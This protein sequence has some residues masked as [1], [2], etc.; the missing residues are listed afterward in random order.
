MQTPSISCVPGRHFFG[1]TSSSSRLVLVPPLGTQAPRAPALRSKCM[2]LGQQLGNVPTGR[3]PLHTGPRRRRWLVGVAL[4]GGGA[5]GALITHA[6]AASPGA[7][8]EVHAART[9]V[10]ERADRPVAL[11]HRARRR[12]WLVGVALEVVGR[13]VP[14]SRTQ[15]PRGGLTRGSKCVPRSQQLG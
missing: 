1:P 5:A 2:P 10:G 3:S 13:P 6:G 12:R 14:S 8:L 11:A 4:G 15:A 9:A 7:A